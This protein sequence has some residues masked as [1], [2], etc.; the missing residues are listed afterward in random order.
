MNYKISD[1]TQKRER[2]QLINELQKLS[3]REIIHQNNNY[4]DDM[5]SKLY[6]L[7]QKFEKND[8]FLQLII[9]H[10]KGEV[11]FVFEEYIKKNATTQKQDYRFLLKNIELL[12]CIEAKFNTILNSKLDLRTYK[13]SCL[14]ILSDKFNEV[15][16][17]DRYIEILKN[18]NQTDLAKLKTYFTLLKELAELETWLF[19]R[20][21]RI[22]PYPK[23]KKYFEET[24]NKFS[25]LFEMYENNLKTVMES[26]K[27]LDISSIK[28]L[29]DSIDALSQIM[30]Q[31]ES[32]KYISTLVSHRIDEV[33]AEIHQ[34]VEKFSNLGEDRKFQAYFDETFV[35]IQEN[36]L[37]LIS[38]QNTFKDLYLNENNLKLKKDEINRNLIQSMSNLLTNLDQKID[39]LINSRTNFADNIEELS[40][41]FYNSYYAIIS[42]KLK[43]PRT[44][45]EF[46]SG[47]K[48]VNDILMEK[49]HKKLN[50]LIEC[51]K[52]CS[53]EIKNNNQVEENFEKISEIFL[54]IKYISNIFFMFKAEIDSKLDKLLNSFIKENGGFEMVGKLALQLRNTNN[55]IGKSLAKFCNM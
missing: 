48:N 10:L 47:N 53:E 20:Q 39:L 3:L 35:K 24:Q 52:E 29:I 17:I 2:N 49:I 36:V 28:H 6:G 4:G 18:G 25:S 1:E 5:I 50:I 31:I 33:I 8:K 27:S 23:F 26:K 21:I 37:I 15:H 16:I 9:D 43:M 7:Y 44:Y 19:R 51:A 11:K 30:P 40:N 55:S 45:E 38:I 14:R 42:F 54:E 32:K 34:N 41:N 46:F 13:D 22:N 12:I